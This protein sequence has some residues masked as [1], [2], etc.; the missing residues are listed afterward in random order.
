MNPQAR[1]WL[2]GEQAEPG[3]TPMVLASAGLHAIAAVVILLL[4]GGLFQRTPPPV[5]AYT[6]KIV[7]PSALGGRLPKGELQPEKPPTGVTSPAPAEEEKKEPP[8]EKKVEVE[9]PPEPEPPK[10]EEKAVVLPEATKKPEPKPTAPPK[11]KPTPVAAKPKATPKPSREELARLDRDNDIQDAIRRLGEK[12][13]G[14]EA[15]GLGGREEGKGA[16]LGTGGDGGG[17]GV[18]MGL[19]FI[20]YKNQVEGIIKKN[21]TWVGSNPNLTI[22]IGF[23]IADA[24]EIAN[25][26]IVQRSGDSSYDDSVVRAIRI[27]NP[28]PRPPEK[29]RSVFANYE[30]EFVSGN[31]A[32]GGG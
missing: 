15:S 12:G 30:L 1:A 22:R 31:L 7:D 28:L 2:S 11:A 14:K 21:W 4:P 9:K 10:P 19:D 8:P 29:Y 18:L 5:I 20:I 32:S 13:K 23:T 24:G 6:V 26:R 16:A 27:S 17:G 25:L 3:L